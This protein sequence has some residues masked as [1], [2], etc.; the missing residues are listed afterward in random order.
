MELEF[1]MTMEP[2]T[3]T[4]QEH[5]VTMRK[6]RPVFYNPPEV[7]GARQKLTAHLSRHRPDEMIDKP[8]ELLVK[9]CFLKSDISEAARWR[10]TK[11]DTDNLNKMLKDCMTKVGFWTDDALVCREITEKF[12]VKEKPGI[13]IRVSELE[14]IR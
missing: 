10:H 8:V 11:P 4:A 2:P 7:E 6:G 13:Y 5:K 3:A 14:D 12:W 9:W 1:F